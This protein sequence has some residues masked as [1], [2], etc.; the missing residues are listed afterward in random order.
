MNPEELIGY[1]CK[2]FQEEKFDE[3]LEAF[4]LAYCKGYE[5]EWIL[6]TIEQ[7]YLSGN[8]EAFRK[9]Y[10]AH[11]CAGV[12][13]EAC[14]LDFVPYREGEYYIFDRE[15][16]AFLGRF[17]AQELAC[18]KREP[19]FDEMKFS[20]AALETDWDWAKKQSVLTEAKN[21]KIYVVAHEI[22]RCVSFCKI[23]ELEEYAKNLRFFSSY[24]SFQ[25][26]FHRRTEEYLPQITF[27]T[28]E[29]RKELESILDQEHAYRLTPEGRSEDHVLLTIAVPTYHRGHLLLKRIE[30]LRSMRYDAEIEIVIS[31]NGT[32]LYQD[33]YDQ[34]AR[35]ADARIRYHDHGRD[36]IYW[37]NWLY[38]AGMAHGTY[39]L[40]VSDEDDVALQGLEHYFKLLSEHPEA[41]LV[42]A[43]GTFQNSAVSKRKYGKKGA[44]AFD[45][46][47]LSQ[48]Y[49]SGII[50]RR[51]VFL[52]LKL[53][54]LEEF[55]GNAFF[56][57]Y[58]HEW[59]RALMSQE[60]D[61]LEEPEILI[62]EGEAPIEKNEQTGDPVLPPHSTYESRMNQFDGMVEFLRWMTKANQQLAASGL[63]WAIQQTG[64]LFLVAREYKYDKEHFEERMDE[65]C[66]KAMNAID[67][68]HFD[69]ADNVRLLETLRNSC[70]CMLSEHAKMNAEEEKEAKEDAKGGPAKKQ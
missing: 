17:S 32:G 54:R 20:A 62:I 64:G 48:S 14:A 26:Y 45:L 39:V 38:A 53:E 58:P 52:Q 40:F 11:S 8:E 41:G 47:F 36:L 44:E 21:R 51:E 7:C 35:I 55:S 24:E 2:K 50:V 23:P 67:G 57:T 27:G 34:A 31:K 10:A 49:L 69:E 4:V 15:R 22:R 5:R 63:Y 12:P 46:A 68:F 59:W 56:Q 1:A 65:Y 9:A 13:Y 66:R 60:G 30:N 29:G 3:A 16:A 25:D 18:A 28:E 6:E 33:E 70:V 42:Q 61:Y 43:R 37:K 19:L